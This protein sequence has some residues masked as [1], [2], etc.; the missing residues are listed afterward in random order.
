MK[1]LFRRAHISGWREK[2]RRDVYQGLLSQL[3]L[4]DHAWERDLSDGGTHFI[5]KVQMPVLY[6]ALVLPDRRRLEV[7]VPLKGATDDDLKNFD[8]FKDR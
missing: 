5:W 8:L 4:S 2:L 3:S 1:S 6:C 7:L